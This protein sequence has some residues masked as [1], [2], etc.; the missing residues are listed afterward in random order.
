MKHQSKKDKYAEAN[1][2]KREKELWD[3]FAQQLNRERTLQFS[4]G[5]IMGDLNNI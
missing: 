4:N 1:A 2:K 5:L 3:D